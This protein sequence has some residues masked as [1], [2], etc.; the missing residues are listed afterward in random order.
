MHLAQLEGRELES[1]SAGA[2]LAT[3]SL[4]RAAPRTTTCTPARGLH[5]FGR[6]EAARVAFEKAI[7]L[8]ER[9][10]LNTISHS[11]RGVAGRDGTARGSAA[12]PATPAEDPPPAVAHVVR[13]VREL[14]EQAGAT[15]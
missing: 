13:A 4:H 1:S 3:C 15:L 10:K 8:A 11:G 9:H 7:E 14:W 12:G 5:R 2:R 6:Q